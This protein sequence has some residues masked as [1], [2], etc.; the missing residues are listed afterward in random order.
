MEILFYAK[1][2]QKVISGIQEKARNRSECFLY[3]SV[4]RKEAER[5]HV[6]TTTYYKQIARRREEC[7]FLI[8]K[9]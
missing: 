4:K 7:Y 9:F 5:G 8:A 2:K 6:N 3:L 1:S